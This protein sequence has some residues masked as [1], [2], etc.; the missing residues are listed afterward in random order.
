MYVSGLCRSD[1]LY[2]RLPGVPLFD[3]KVCQPTLDTI[4]GML[5]AGDLESTTV[6]G[7][8]LGGK[9][10]KLYNKLVY[11]RGGQLLMRL[12]AENK[13]L[14]DPTLSTLCD[15]Y[16]LSGDRLRSGAGKKYTG[17]H[18]STGWGDIGFEKNLVLKG[19]NIPSGGTSPTIEKQ[20]ISDEKHINPSLF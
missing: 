10:I 18:Q 6:E 15:I 7:Q 14:A 16:S 4:F 12:L 11:N 1:N 5:A 9:K 3:T 13:L 17:L 8:F 20:P 19:G 2:L